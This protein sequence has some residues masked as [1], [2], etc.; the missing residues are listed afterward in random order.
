MAYLA[1]TPLPL[2]PHK[3]SR[4]KKISNICSRDVCMYAW[5]YVMYVMYV[6][7]VIYVYVRYAC[8]VCM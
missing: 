7:Y 4:P 6:M 8:D 2:P 3:I 5:V 1:L